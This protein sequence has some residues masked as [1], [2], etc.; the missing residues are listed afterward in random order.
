MPKAIR[1][2]QVG[3]PEVLQWQD[4]TVGPPGPREARVRHS[5]AG[6]NFID[7]YHRTGLYPQ[8]LPFIPGSEGAGVVTAVGA[9]VKDLAVGDRVAYAGG[10]LGAYSEERLIAADWLVKLPAGVDEQVAASM[11]LKGMTAQFLLRQAVHVE[12]GDT[13]LLHA[14]AG[15]VGLIATQWAKHL[16]ATVI[17]TVGSEEKAA[18]ARAHG[19][20][21]V[22]FY[23]R[24]NVAARVKELTGGKGV[25]VVY[26]P[27][28]KDTWERSLDCLAPLGLLVAF[29]NSSG[30]VPPVNLGIL[31]LKGSLYVQ[32]PTLGSYLSSREA[33]QQM[34]D[35]LFEMVQSGKVKVPVERRYP[36][37]DAARA[38]RDLESRMTTGAGVLVP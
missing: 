23:D 25:N 6:L 14:A 1:M 16:G 33:A 17:G 37:A 10:P 22:V 12:P 11:M 2:H 19:C 5:F 27:V 3:G 28:G 29:G 38:H 8:P 13:I 21:H 7:V 20:D 35:E 36:L 31:S 15:G 9:E 18:L 26:D 34:A 4:V 24:E 30:P 32:R